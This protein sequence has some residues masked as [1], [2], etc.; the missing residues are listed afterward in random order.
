[1]SCNTL[2]L[3]TPS[4]R[5]TS[6][7][8]SL[9]P[10][11]ANHLVEQAHRVAHTARGFASDHAERCLVALDLLSLEHVAKPRRDHLRRDQLEVEALHPAQ[12]GDRHLVHFGRR[13]D[14]FDVRGGSS[15]VF[16]NAFQ[17]F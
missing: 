11:H 6:S 15:S 5:A 13:E 2:R 1:M 14:E 12:D 9:A 10:P 3:A 8:V 4:T 7:P 16:K 17:A